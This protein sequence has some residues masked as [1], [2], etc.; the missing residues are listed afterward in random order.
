[1]ISSICSFEIIN[2]LTLN[3][4][5]FLCTPVSAADAA[6]NPNGIKTFL[7]H[8]LRKFF[9]KDNPVFSNGF[10]SLARNPPDCIISES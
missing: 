8:G 1:M 4:K 3:R 9:I 10:R 7:P 2:V 6:V 5:I